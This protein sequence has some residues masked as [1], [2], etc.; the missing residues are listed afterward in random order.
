MIKSIEIENYKNFKHLKMENFKLIN[1]FTGQNDAG[2]TNLLEAL[3]T[4]TG[5]CDPTANQVSLPPE[6]AVNISE[7]RK[8]KLDADNL[9]TFFYQGNTAN[10]ISIRT[11][12]EHA[13]IPLTIQYPTQTSYSKDIN[14][15]SDDAHMTNLIN[16]T[17]TKPQ[18]QFSYNPSLSPMTMTY[19]FER[20][21]L[22]L[23]H[24]NLDKIAQTYKEN[25]MFIPIELSIV[26]SLKALENLQLASK[27][28]ELIEILQC[29]NPNILNANTIRKSVYIQIKDENTPLEESPKRLLNSF[30]WG[31]IKFFIMVSILIDNRVKYLFIDEIESGLHHTK[32]QEFLKALFKLAQKLQIQIFAT[33]HN[34]EFLLNAINTMPNNETGVF[35]DIALFELEKESASGF[36]RH[37]YSMLEEALHE[38]MEVRG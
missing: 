33:T 20:Q 2:K 24:S 11:E 13:T 32:M 21:N 38:G 18:L 8:I 26:N 19:E 35:K 27:E 9:K 14:L 29:F 10:P 28:K 17:I 36:I 23:I 22:G 31:F 37:S 6:H 3:Y 15:N 4:N 1:F 5:L 12:F 7:F 25:A 30:G 34:K 16:T